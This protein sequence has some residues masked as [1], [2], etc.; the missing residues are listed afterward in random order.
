M[1]G[2]LNYFYQDIGMV[3][4]S[5]FNIVISLFEA[6]NY[7]FNFSMR[8]RMIEAYKSDFGPLDWVMTILSTVMTITICVLL[9]VIV[10]KVLK[11]ALRFRIPVK[12]YDEMAEKVKQL[13]RDVIKLNYE[14]DKILAMKVSEMG[15]TPNSDILDLDGK[16]VNAD[17][18]SNGEENGDEGEEKENKGF[19]V[20]DKRNKFDSPPVDPNESRFFRLTTVDNYYKV[21]YKPPEWDDNI[22][23]EELCN[24]MRLF[25]A[26]RLG[27][28]YDIRIIR[29][30]I[31]SL[32]TTRILILQG[33]SGTGKTSLAY[34][35]GKFVQRDTSIAS[36]QPSWRE[37]TELFGYFNEFTRKFNETDFLRAVYEANYYEDPHIVVLDE[38]NI[39]R[40][41]YYFA[42]MLS[43]LEM[44]RPEEWLIDIIS[45]TWDN[46]PVLLNGGKIHI[47][48]NT[49]FVGT[50][51]ND[52]STF[53]V[54][55]KVYDRA[56]VIDLDSKAV[57]FDAPDTEP[58]HVRTE[59]L[60]KLYAEA[61][62]AYPMSA[63]IQSK[64][65]ELDTYL[66]THFRLAFGNR[67]MKQIRDFIPCFIACGGTE[68]DAVDFIVAKKVFRKFESLSLGFMKDELRKFSL[69]LDTLFGRGKMPVC[70]EYIERLQKMS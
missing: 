66:I 43:I 21:Q 34:A 15:M 16:N 35:F 11:K 58:V 14:K 47:N 49:W 52:D 65:N 19:D 46:D 27:L 28:Y 68:L 59:H 57:K 7:L 69:Y 3:V 29:Y 31:A 8:A 10:V 4:R 18:E 9:V 44:P 5:I 6:L 23:L 13:T 32:G 48:D 61:K 33:I 36:V 67:I 26:S 22:T 30:L 50:I 51:N 41:E 2:F 53:A 17:G 63:E 45:T 62:E 70:Q 12:Q 25:S 37:R 20:S 24:R 64:L 56:V 54:A 38:M 1:D 40:V 55:D 60:K 42:E 39:A